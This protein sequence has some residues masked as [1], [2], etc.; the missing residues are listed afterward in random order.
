MRLSESSFLKGSTIVIL[1][2]LSFA[3]TN[4]HA[5]GCVLDDVRLVCGEQ[6]S[7][8]ILSNLAA[9]E[10]KKLLGKPLASISVFD[11]PNDLEIFRKSLEAS[12]SSI[13]KEAEIQRQK[14]L[15]GKISLKAFDDYTKTY[16]KARANY[17]SGITFY[18]TLVWHG[19]TGKAPPKDE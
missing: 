5:E 9:P 4:S 17:D 11:E 19:K 13:S 18:R 2:A 15:T 3:P 12:W 10:T 16:Q 8:D 1:A 14:M 7:P 6:K